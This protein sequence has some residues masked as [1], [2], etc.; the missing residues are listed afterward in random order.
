MSVRNNNRRN[1]EENVDKI[2]KKNTSM[3]FEDQGQIQNINN[4]RILF[5]SAKM[6]K[7][8]NE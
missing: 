4:A 2:I 6:I 7:M 3:Q 1:I 5:R 8:V